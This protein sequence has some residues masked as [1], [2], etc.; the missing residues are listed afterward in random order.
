MRQVIARLKV[1]ALG[2]AA[3]L[4]PA[5][6]PVML[7]GPGSA[8]ALCRLMA[9]AGATKVMVVTDRVL[10]EL[11]I[12]APILAALAKAGISAEIFADVEPDPT[13][14]LVMKGVGRFRAAGADAVLAIGGGSSIDAAKAIVACHSNRCRPEALVGYFKVRRQTV[15][16]FVAPTTAGSGSE[17][18]IVSIVSDP[19][20][21]RKLA[22]VDGKL[23]PSCVALDPLLMVGLPPAV[24]AATGM[25]ALTHAVESFVST[26]ATLETRMLSK[27]A[28]SAI[29]R[30]LVIV[31]DDGTDI[32]ARERMA[33]A[34]CMAGLAFTRASIGYVHAIA[35][36]LGALYHVPH[37][38]ANAVTLPHVLDFSLD[39]VASRLADL[40]RLCRLGHEGDGDRELALA[41]VAEIRRMNA[42]M[43]IPTTIARLT[44]ADM[45]EIAR[46]ALAEAHGTYPVPKYMNHAQCEALL[47][48]MLPADPDTQIHESGRVAQGA[49]G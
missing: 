42:H 44:R 32:G 45:P 46:R 26:L 27:S 7:T 4:L 22:I 14:D 31:Y 25:D 33:V 49:A 21:K 34:S 48:K 10:V 29:L 15:P 43:K 19:D 16:L 41:F 5:P 38:V 9:D 6:R 2:V 35:H 8:S 11:N 36:Q 47:E 20:T 28:T 39:A 24:T 23:V 30:D 37:G 17:V 3:K 18:T 1:R 40:A 12:I 13:I